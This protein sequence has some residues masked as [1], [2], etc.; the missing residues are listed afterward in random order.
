[1]VGVTHPQPAG[2]TLAGHG[3]HRWL[4]TWNLPLK[5]KLNGIRITHGYPDQVA[6]SDL[7]LH[8][9]TNADGHEYGNAYSD[10]Y[11]CAHRHAYSH[12]T[13]C[14]GPICAYHPAGTAPVV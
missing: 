4:S 6:N 3:W 13:R 1:M 14:A 2:N 10:G 8:I 11:A 12:T 5:A 9:N 7:N